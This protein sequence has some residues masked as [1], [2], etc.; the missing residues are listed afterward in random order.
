[1]EMLLVCSRREGCLVLDDEN[2]SCLVGVRSLEF[3]ISALHIACV[4]DLRK[5]PALNEIDAADD[6]WAFGD[7]LQRSRL[8]DDDRCVC[9]K[10][11]YR[12]TIDAELAGR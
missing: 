10:S 1:M 9:L 12:R 7:S 2:Q 6:R 8:V 3:C 5:F 4:S 11:N